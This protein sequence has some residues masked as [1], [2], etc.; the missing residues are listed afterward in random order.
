MTNTRQIIHLYNR[1]GFGIHPGNV[2]NRKEK[3]MESLVD[4]LFEDSK[5]WTDLK[6][7]EDIRRNS[8]AVGGLKILK[9]VLKSKSDLGILNLKWMNKMAS[10]KAQLREKMTFFWHNHFATSEPF[11]VLMQEQIN[12]IRRHALGNFGELLLQVS[13]DPAMIL[14]LNNQ[15]NKKS[16][17]NENFAREL[18]ELFT[19]GRGNYTETDIREAA[20]A[21]TGWSVGKDGYFSKKQKE[22]DSDE[23]T[24]LGKT[25]NW[26][27][28][29]IIRIILE[30]KQTAVFLSTKIYRQFVNPIVE[31]R[32]VN[33]MAEILYSSEYDITVL[34][35][36]VLKSEWFYATENLGCQIKS[37][38]ELLV[39]Y[40]RILGIQMKNTN[41]MLKLQRTLGQVL[42]FP[43]NVAGWPGNRAW[44]DSSSLLLRL[45]L[46]NLF[47]GN[48]SYTP[49]E[50]KLPETP[51]ESDKSKRKARQSPF[52]C[53]MN[54]Q[55]IEKRLLGMKLM[56]IIQLLIQ[57]DS[58]SFLK[59]NE[60][61]LSK[62]ND[63]KSIISYLLSTPEYQLN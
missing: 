29:D 59:R 63:L 3:S 32:R 57:T 31:S 21:F 7:F 23:K 46:M 15:Q 12:T 41:Q 17:P 9:M 36:F 14:W 10:D 4:D 13:K 35:K 5:E 30:Q 37:P 39:G 28:E 48:T 52:I 53:A 19:L 20:R 6:E 27:G 8:K 25:G 55:P 34:M 51:Q 42:F 62:M 2:E 33:D 54:W 50:K 49:D 58:E 1:A 44:I 26:D 45:N 61:P 18:L 56:E 60:E 16:A 43:P 24:F 11:P 38:V 22:R 40:K 47:L